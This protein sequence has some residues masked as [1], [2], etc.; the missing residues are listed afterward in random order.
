MLAD[1]RNVLVLSISQAL[2]LSAIVLAMTLGA[3][4]GTELAPDKGLATLPIAAMV[5]GTAL[6][7][8]PAAA[9]MQRAGRR[10]G[11][12]FGAA[13]GLVGGL[14]AALAVFTQSFVL[15][16]FAHVLMGAYQGFAHYYRFAAAEVASP[17]FASRAISL[18]IAGGVVAAFL[19]PQLVQWTRDALLPHAF[20]GSYLA[21]AGLGVLAVLILSRL[22]RLAPPRGVSQHSSRS[23]REIARQP[24]FLVAVSGAAVGYAVMLLAMTATPVAMLGCGLPVADAVSVIQ[25]HVLGMFAPSFFT[26]AL[27]QRFGAT[28][29]MLAG[30]ALLAGHVV[31][32]LSGVT[33]L[34]FLSALVLLGVGWNFSFI[35][36]TAL[37]T[38]TYRPQEQAKAQAANDFTVFTLVAI[39]SLAAG[40]LHDRHGWQTLNLVGLALLTVAIVITVWFAASRSAVEG[41]PARTKVS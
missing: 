23:L 2:M 1:R 32:S 36:A 7:T 5:V 22:D 20:L 10:A 13:L 28:K 35:G 11:F 8:L 9:F 37:L 34:H 16:V 29:V 27:V 30:F 26:G 6:T 40:W 14:L 33:F 3:L 4:I 12:Q 39:A 41:T 38:R 24:A 25:W 31:I 19:G 17:D 21:Q 15:F 18:V